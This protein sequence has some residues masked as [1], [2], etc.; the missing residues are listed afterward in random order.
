[1]PGQDPR[2]WELPFD[3]GDLD[4]LPEEVFDALEEVDGL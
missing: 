1:M 3:P 2:F 4:T